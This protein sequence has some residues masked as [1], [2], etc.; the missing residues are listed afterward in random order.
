M[1]DNTIRVNII[2]YS[3]D[4]LCIQNYVGKENKLAHG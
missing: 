3:I 2:Q 1:R 4:L